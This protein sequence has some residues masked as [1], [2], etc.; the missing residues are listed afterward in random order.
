MKPLERDG[1]LALIVKRIY[2]GYDSSRFM[3][4][5]N[6]LQLTAGRSHLVPNRAGVIRARP[7][8]E[9]EVVAFEYAVPTNNH[10]WA[11]SVR[12]SAV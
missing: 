4:R 3:N 11:S 12:G 10:G 9:P 2:P 7:A 1:S 5:P 6:R 8:D